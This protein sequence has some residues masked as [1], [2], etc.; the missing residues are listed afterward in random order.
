MP[1]QID[2]IEMTQA[3][4]YFNYR[5]Q[6]SGLAADN[7]VPLVEHKPTILR[8]Y[9]S[10]DAAPDPGMRISGAVICYRGT[11]IVDVLTPINGPI[12]LIPAR[13]GGSGTKMWISDRSRSNGTLNFLIP[14]A[15][16]VGGLWASV[17]VFNADN[18]GESSLLA[19]SF[20]FHAT[21][22]PTIVWVLIHF[23]GDNV[24][25]PAPTEGDV[26]ATLN[27]FSRMFPYS[28]FQSAFLNWTYSA[29][30]RTLD[31][32]A[33]LVGDLVTMRQAMGPSFW[34][35]Y[36]VGV[37]PENILEAVT[38][39]HPGGIEQ[40]GGRAAVAPAKDGRRMA[41]ELGHM[42]GYEMHVPGCVA[43]DLD[44]NYPQ[45]PQRHVWPASIGE[46]GFDYGK[47]QI[48]DPRY[49]SEFMSYCGNLECKN[50]CPE[51]WISPYVYTKLFANAAMMKR[52]GP[53]PRVRSER[54]VL[55][56]RMHR[57]GRVDLLPSFH[58]SGLSDQP[59]ESPTSPVWVAMLG[60][61][62]EILE[63]A[64]CHYSTPRQ[65]PDGP[66]VRL[67][68]VLP[69]HPEAHTLAFHRGDQTVAKI[70]IEENT[71]EIRIDTIEHSDQA[72]HLIRLTWNA[73]H[74]YKQM[75]YFVRYTNNNG[76]TWHPLEAGAKQASLV[77]N[78]ALLPGGPACK[79]Q[80]IATS[81]IRTA[82]A[83]S[84]P[85]EVPRKP[86]QAHIV[87]PKT[88]ATFPFGAV[89]AFTGAGF[90]PDH[91]MSDFDDIIWTSNR[92]GFL[93][94]GFEVLA[95]TL[96]LGRHRV[97]LSVPDGMGGETCQSVNIE[98][99]AP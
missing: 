58:L 81:G 82:V 55:N 14:A 5:G 98:V 30:L 47:S 41:H 29:S 8:V 86:R 3:I 79:F 46:C 97:T 17:E 51:H 88:G 43:P 4:Q 92:D 15:Q 93:G 53:V 7:S 94:A 36:F 12:S 27:V 66:Y 2:G 77:V 68:E 56:V 44:N 11:T 61:D 21:Q 39:T 24:D 85:F 23:T 52:M 13:V 42:L 35:F 87:S 70:V 91:G 60:P 18:R 20:E 54:L 59:D 34:G 1:L 63:S 50:N 48:Y 33:A 22:M 84:S 73:E 25:L 71:P 99:R 65:R 40:A 78:P 62:G 72:P 57:D 37:L 83:D 69:W 38:G 10:V 95:H 75:T 28:G 67:R 64:S 80:V 6:G 31:D 76:E 89:V 26:L 45:Y 19:T 16:C 90:S 32:W 74:P 49:T 96:S 9:A